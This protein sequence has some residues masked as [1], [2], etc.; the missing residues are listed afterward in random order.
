M[1]SMKKKTVDSYFK[2]INKNKV[3][4]NMYTK[5]HEI[6]SIVDEIIKRNV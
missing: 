2:R 3:S 5:Q 6:L 4:V 1:E